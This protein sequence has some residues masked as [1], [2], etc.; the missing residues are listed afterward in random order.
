MDLL[1]YLN[2][3]LANDNI[4]HHLFLIEY[5]PKRKVVHCFF[6]GK[7]DESFYGSAALRQLS[8]FLLMTT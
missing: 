4:E 2:K 6:E 5:N 3:E 1:K 8:Y 7:T